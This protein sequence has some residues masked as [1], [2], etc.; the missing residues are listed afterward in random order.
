[1]ERFVGKGVVLGIVSG[2]VMVPE[3]EVKIPEKGFVKDTKREVGRFKRAVEIAKEELTDLYSYALKEV[4]EENAMIFDIHKLM[5]EDGDLLEGVEEL[6]RAEK[7][8]A[9]YAVYTV[10]ETFSS[11][12]S[13]M[14]DEY[15]K[16]RALDIADVAKRLI[17]ILSDRPEETVTFEEPRIVLADDLTPSETMKMDKTKI[18]AF[19]TV[20]G[21]AN[22][23]T[24]ILA[25]ALDIPTLVNVEIKDGKLAAYHGKEA[26][27]DGVEEVLYID[28]DE[29]LY[30]KKYLEELRLKEE[31]QSLKELKG[32][33]NRTRDGRTIEVYANIGCLDDLDSVFENDAGGIGLFRS[34]Y[35][36]LCREDMP[37]E[38]WLF[39]TYK[40][41]AERLYGKKVVIRTLDVGADKRAEYLNLREEENPALGFRAIRISFERLQNFKAQIRAIY[42]AAYFGNVDIM[43]PMIASLWEVKKI[44]DIISEVK[45]EL[46]REGISYGEPAVGIMIETP[47]AA[48]ISD[49]LAKEVDFFSIGTNDLT[50]YTL[51]ID[52]QNEHLSKYYDARHEAVLRL[53]ELAVLNA[54]ANGIPVGICGEMAADTELTERFLDMGVD[55]LSVAPPKVLPLR[56]KIRSI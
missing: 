1:M 39:R 3:T 56:E 47:A 18:L 37:E 27:V 49:L 55:K 53:I 10:G 2:K 26:I 5:L 28:P 46:T 9:E 15:M 20:K 38:E 8:S 16:E 40:E 33:E 31:K 50:Q 35:L 17:R 22:S 52:R 11:I 45:E 36:Y 48:V 43:F 7:V 6:I 25:K 34:E 32:K 14:E 30:K 21:S 54:H 41:V 44:K 29:A 13:D 12:F 51:A 19:A 24:A 42:R 4:G 23:H